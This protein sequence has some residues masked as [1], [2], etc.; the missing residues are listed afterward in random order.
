MDPR[1]NPDFDLDDECRKALHR[2]ARAIAERE[3]PDTPLTAA[4]AF[5]PPTDMTAAQG[6]A[7]LA[8]MGLVL[9]SGFASS[10]L[11][12]WIGVRFT[13]VVLLAIAAAAAAGL[14]KATFA[15]SRSLTVT[16]RA[17]VLGTFAVAALSGSSRVFALVPAIVH[18]VV[19]SVMLASLRDEMTLIEKGA[20]LSHPLA[21]AFIGPY[22]RK[23]T[24]VWSALFACSAFVT[25]TLALAGWNQAHRAWT[26]W[27]FWTLIAAFCVVEF[28]W[29]KAWF[30]Y[31]GQGPFDRLLAMLFPPANTERGRRSQ[32]YLIGMREELARLAEATRVE[33]RKS[34]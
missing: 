19:A 2:H 28:F 32:A 34:P 7:L 29:R 20:R 23:L 17:L 3:D 18:A 10:H 5:R 6:L 22:C 14:G 16:E 25:A 8:A 30:R 27:L 1:G 26:G 11:T 12:E 24:V 21:P 33:R 15:G 13:S 4:H 9:L 31:Y